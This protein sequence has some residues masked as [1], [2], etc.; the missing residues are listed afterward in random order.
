MSNVLHTFFSKYYHKCT[1]SIV[2]SDSMSYVIIINFLLLCFRHLDFFEMMRSEDEKQMAK[3]F[4]NVSL[5]NISL[6]C[7]T[8]HVH[9]SH[10]LPR[11]F[12]LQTLLN[13]K[14]AIL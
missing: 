3:K 1:E 12:T 10:Y 7:N 14:F 4:E 6:V 8:R 9:L 2:D 13:M 5:D 11:I